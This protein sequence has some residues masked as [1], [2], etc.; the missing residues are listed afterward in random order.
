M[1]NDLRGWGVSEEQY[2]Y[3]A[4]HAEDLVFRMSAEYEIEWI[5]PSVRSLGWEPAEVVARRPWEFVSPDDVVL[6]E[7]VE[8]DLR[9]DGHA[10][11]DVRLRGKDERFR[12]FSFRMSEV[13][14]TG[15]GVCRIGSGRLIEAERRTRQL[16]SQSEDR[17]HAIVS[18][19]IDPHVM[20]QAIRD[21]T[22]GIVDFLYV[23]ANDAACRYTGLSY[24]EL[25]GSRL[26]ELLPGQARQG[27]FEAYCR[28]IETGEP[29]IIDDYRFVQDLAVMLGEERRYDV[30][31]VRIGD[32]LSYVWRDVTDR[33][34]ER[35]ALASSEERFR[36][37]VSHVP[38]GIAVLD[39]TD[40]FVEVNPALCQFL[41]RD[42]K[43]LLSH[44]LEHVLVPGE[45]ARF[46]QM[47]RA[48]LEGKST[49]ESAEQAFFTGTGGVVTLKNGVA[50]AR[51]ADG[52]P[53]SFVCQ[54]VTTDGRAERP[55]PGRGAE[56]IR[57][58]V[59]APTH[60]SLAGES[61][62]AL[63][64]SDS[65]V[66]V[67]SVSSLSGLQGQVSTDN[68]DV[69]V[70]VTSPDSATLQQVSDVLA[71]LEA[72]PT[73]GLVVVAPVRRRDV[74]GLL[75]EGKRPVAHLALSTGL[76]AQTL[77]QAMLATNE[78]LSILDG[79]SATGDAA[80]PLDRLTER[81]LEVL[82]LLARGLDNAAIAA[83]LVVTTKAVENCI[84][85]IFR[86]LDLSD[87]FGI[88]RRV[89]AS[90]LYLEWPVSGRSRS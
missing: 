31:V 41:E 7:R 61:M 68:T 33:Y 20:L 55:E 85:S 34:R 39:L 47:R 83:E 30:R 63:L 44:R 69:V 79:P 65:R 53:N 51:D 75:T 5:S 24:K 67:A 56:W 10:S 78:G 66:A 43:W 71:E 88:N 42:E 13:E 11:L 14:S 54:L 36:L 23:D 26:L 64:D 74:Q 73:V 77:V 12:W 37:A 29:L 4:E 32:S 50:L 90:L 3:L 80:T 15:G 19:L 35:Q 9:R 48:L 46:R 86:K 62:A 59:A 6:L 76:D 89:R 21:Q 28:V 17:Y 57:V 70:L 60:A 16:L 8:D 40:S 27:M 1:E 49:A 84:G 18:T 87:E 38:M 72:H 52:S 22:G 2:R 81:E 45:L 58:T 82:D 25:V